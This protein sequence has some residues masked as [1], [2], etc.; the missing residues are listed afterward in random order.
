MKHVHPRWPA[1]GI[2]AA[3]LALPLLAGAGGA[4]LAQSKPVVMQDPGGTYGEALRRIMYDPFTKETGIRVLTVQE[5]R[6]GP[7]I[8]A[9]VEAGKTE[10]DLAFIFDQ[11]TKQL[12]DCCLAEIDYSKL[13]PE[14]QKVLKTLPETAIRPKGVA[15]QVIGVLMAYNKERYKKK[16]PQ[17]WAD[18]WNV[19]DFPGKRCLPGWPRFVFEAALLADG[20]PKEKLYPVDMDRALKKVAE[21]KPH[22]VKW[23]QTN[24]QAPQLLLDGEADMCMA[25]SGRIGTLLRDEPDAPIA[26]TWQDAFIYYDF[27]SIPKNSPNPDAAMKLLSW[28]MDPTRAARL[29]EVANV[30]LP[31]PLVYD[32]GN[33]KVRASWSNSPDATAKGVQ[34]S[35]DYWGSKAPDGRTMEEYGQEK[36]NELLAK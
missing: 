34:W 15:L 5:A 10:W 20:V 6:G 4:A 28:R 14:A 13:T 3:M 18:F 8:K 16:L 22:V 25:Y 36:L 21:I 23:W 11:E 2:T 30:P 19:K 27:F 9:Q 24:V 26:A 17:N 32:A 31:S 1:R 29:A 33:P 12:G 35:A 7:R